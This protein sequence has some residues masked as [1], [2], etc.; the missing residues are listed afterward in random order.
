MIEDPGAK[1]NFMTNAFAKGMDL[2]IRMEE[3]QQ[4]A[5]LHYTVGPTNQKIIQRIK[6]AN[7]RQTAEDKKST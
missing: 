7:R 5:D 6:I 1:H 2:S 4:M 3:A